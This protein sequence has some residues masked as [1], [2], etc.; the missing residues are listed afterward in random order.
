MSNFNIIDS[1]YFNTGGHCMVL[2][3]TIYDRKANRTFYAYTNEES[4]LLYGFDWIRTGLDNDP[5]V[6]N[7][8]YIIGID[9]YS[10]YT[11]KR[12]DFIEDVYLTLIKECIALY[13]REIF[14]KEDALTHLPLDLILDCKV[15]ALPAGYEDWWYRNHS[16]DFMFDGISIYIDS[17]F[18]E[19]LYRDNEELY[20]KDCLVALVEHAREHSSDFYHKLP[21][22][23]FINEDLTENDKYDMLL[24]YITNM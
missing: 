11:P 9:S 16:A 24:H 10:N 4:C 5:S 8:Y 15:E 2:I 23:G 3:S 12:Y 1:E 20:V 17:D 7:K 21:Y 22:I 19:D 18:Y 14:D 13:A 6:I